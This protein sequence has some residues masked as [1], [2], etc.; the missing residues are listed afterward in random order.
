MYK[1]ITGSHAVSHAVRVSR[2]EVITA[3]PI[4]P[5]TSIVELLSEFCATGELK[6]NFVKVESEHSAMATL[7]GSQATGARSFTATSSHGLA[8]MHEMLHWALGARLP[9]VMANVNRAMG[10]PWSIW[11]DHNDSLSQR[12]TG[13]LQVYVESGQ[14]VLD[15][16]IMAFKIA[17]QVYL[18]FMVNLDGFLLSHTV[19]PVDIPDVKLVDEY[20]PPLKMKYKLDVD[21]PHSIGNLT[22]PDY[23]YELRYKA[24]KAFEEALPLVN[25]EGKLF[26]DMFGRYYA[27]VEKV[28]CDDADL[29]VIAYSTFT[30]TVRYTIEKLRNEGKKVGL[31]K[32]RLF[33]PF[34]EEDIVGAVP[35][36]ARIVVV[37]RNVSFGSKGIFASEI[38][39]AL[40]RL[41]RRNEVFPFVA[42]LG[43]RDLTPE[44]FERII[45]K[46]YDMTTPAEPIIW[47]GV[48]L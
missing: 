44:V 18:P 16:I 34:P 10:T 32:I 47:E 20:L 48:K 17:E 46:A 26:G 40:C 31:L 23:Y 19:E 36:N 4:T 29:V 15:S 11:V 38:M 35:E 13:W 9:I 8:L 30:S 39:S 37:D 24:Q 5:Q 21:D 27:A 22:A 45:N 42:G 25:K 14:E 41:G 3:Y 12:D 7:I 2:A 1:V 43:G 28:H 6:A 33:R